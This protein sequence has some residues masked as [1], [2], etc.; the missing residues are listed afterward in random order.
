MPLD[1][2][3]LMEFLKELEK[4][5]E[6]DI[7]LVAAGGT[8]MTLLDL[9]ATTKDIDFTAPKEDAQEFREKEK[10]VSHGLTI[11]CYEDGLV[12]SQILPWDYLAKS[13]PIERVGRIELRA[14]DPVD[15]VVT[16]IGRLNS[17]DMEDIKDC[18]R[19][20]SLRKAEIVA[21]AKQVEYVGREENYQWNLETVIERFF[22]N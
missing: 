20:R 3:Q 18:I 1:R 10:L 21:R 17:R 13:I 2:S 6:R 9:K 4:E 11:Q 15:I 5:L 8:A 14:L 7:T 22:T 16:K 19:L 12:F